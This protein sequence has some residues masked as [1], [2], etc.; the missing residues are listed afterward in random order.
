M[1]NAVR[2]RVVAG[3]NNLL[4]EAYKLCWEGDRLLGVDD[5]ALDAMRYALHAVMQK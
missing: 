3:S 4:N 2:V 5:H 1:I